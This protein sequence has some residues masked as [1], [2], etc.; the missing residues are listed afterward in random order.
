MIE[1]KAR[2]QSPV[3]PRGT[4][5]VSY[6]F[7]DLDDW[8]FRASV[9]WKYVWADLP[10]E[11]LFPIARNDEIGQPLSGERRYRL[12]FAAGQLPP[13]RYWRISMYDLEGFFI[14]N[15]IRR[16]GIG[17]MAEKLQTNSDGS[18]TLYIQ[19]ASPGMEKEVN[20]LPAPK[21]GF[22][23]MM[24]MYQPEERMYRGDYIVP[25][26]QWL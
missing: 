3:Q 17:N 20:W 8:L 25:P 13:A 1:H 10:S 4:W 16:Y 11:L 22:F 21:E 5:M 2:V 15:P 6:D 26:L 19:R 14:D 24:R 23:L 12:H 7:T 9:G 18:L